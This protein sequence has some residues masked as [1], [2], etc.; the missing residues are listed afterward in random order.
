MA[1]VLHL[2]NDQF[3]A[4]YDLLEDTIND[5]Q[6]HLDEDIGDVTLDDYEIYH[7]WKQLDR[8]ISEPKVTITDDNYGDKVDTF[9]G[10]MVASNDNEFTHDSEGC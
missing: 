9:V 6:S 5:I 8:T 4:L 2:T 7:V 1:R 3:G 10:N